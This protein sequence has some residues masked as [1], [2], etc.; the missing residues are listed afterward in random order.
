[1]RLLFC[2]SRWGE[3]F[4]GC[5]AFVITIVALLLFKGWWGRGWW[6][7]VP[8]AFFDFVI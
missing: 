7:H 8:H 1:M 2:R 4:I 3:L 6:K 5:I